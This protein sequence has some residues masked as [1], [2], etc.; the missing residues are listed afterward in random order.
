[1]DLSHDQ[2]RAYRLAVHHLRPAETPPSPR[3]IAAVIGLQNS[4]PGAWEEAVFHRRPDLRSD[5][6]QALLAQD[7]NLLQ[8][9][10]VRG[11][12]L[13]FPT[14]DAP[15]YLTGLVPDH[16]EPWAYTRGLQGALDILNMGFDPLLDL[17]LEVLPRLDREVVV[18]KASLDQIL[19]DDIRPLLPE[20]K[21]PV[22]DQPSPYDA[23]GRQTLGQAVV[24]FLLRPASFLGKVVF[25]EREG[26]TPKFTSYKAWLGQALP[27]SPDP[28]LALLCRYLHA[29]APAKRT[30]FQAWM[31]VG[32]DQAKAIWARAQDQDL[33]AQVTYGSVT[34]FALRQDL[35]A[36]QAPPAPDPDLILV[37]GH[38]PYLGAPD[39]SLILADPAL[40]RKLW[41]TVSNP[42]AI[43][44]RGQAIG[45]W[46]SKVAGQKRHVTLQLWE[47]IGDVAAL[48]PKLRAYAKFRRKPLGDIAVS[49]A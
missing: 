34:A 9:W 37:S 19:A 13:V 41:Q 14:E 29:Y 26:K 7:K 46:K 2:V 40:R 36:F 5:D 15:I 18:S 30:D 17:L 25:A 6:L 32:P 33:L 42:G 43:L 10:S 16:G 22:W 12:P 24:S 35:P 49:Q 38:D 44:R 11:V 8:A 47:D 48:E 3:E 23:S 1:M 27:P 45:T 20:A 31:G 4:P 39:R 28:G 21:R